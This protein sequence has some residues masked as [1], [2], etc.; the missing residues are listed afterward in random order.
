MVR[1]DTHNIED[2]ERAQGVFGAGESGAAHPAQRS[3]S[4]REKVNGVSAPN[5]N[6][7]PLIQ[8]MVAKQR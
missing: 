3:Q 6:T 2:V 8:E 5:T 4:A 7:T 1:G